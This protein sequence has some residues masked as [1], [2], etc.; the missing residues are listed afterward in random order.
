MSLSR[1]RPYSLVLPRILQLCVVK[2]RDIWKALNFAQGLW[3]RL[4][5]HLSPPHLFCQG[6][7]PALAVS[8]KQH[9]KAIPTPF[10]S[11]KRWSHDSLSYYIYWCLF[12]YWNEGLS[13]L[14]W[15]LP[16]PYCSPGW[17]WT[18]VIFSS[19]PPECYGNR[20]KPSY[21]LEVFLSSPCTGRIAALSKVLRGQPW[22]PQICFCHGVDKCPVK[23]KVLKAW[24]TEWYFGEG[25]N[26][27]EV[28]PGGEVLKSLLLTAV[29]IASLP[30]LCASSL[31]CSML[32]TI[33]SGMPT[34]GSKPLL[35]LM[36]DGNLQPVSQKWVLCLYNYLGDF[37]AG[38]ESC[39]TVYDRSAEGMLGTVESHTMWF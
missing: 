21:S 33:A 5:S 36:L 17:S 10:I 23:S 12:C 39:L 32:L 27:W 38:M 2:I 18:H 4:A 11:L 37:V 20:S 15:F 3:S 1:P 28:W 29:M 25:V 26:L 24:S 7:L 35:R 31:F 30:H 13:F 22:D 6:S 19:Q 34:R 8:S 14:F 9:W 16:S